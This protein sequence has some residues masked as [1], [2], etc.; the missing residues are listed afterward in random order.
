MSGASIY[1]LSSR[2]IGQK[3]T[4]D[5]VANNVA[6]VNTHG[7]KKQ[8]VDFEEIIGGTVAKPAGHFTIDRGFANDL[9]QGGMEVTHNPLDMALGTDGFFMIEMNGQQHYTRNG[10]FT[11]D[12]DGNLVT[13]RGYP[14]LDANG[15]PIVL[16]VDA[17]QISVGQDGTIATEQGII[18]QVGVVTFDVNTALIRV[19]DN[20]FRNDGG[21][22]GVPANETARVLQ[23]TLETSNV[24]AVL[25]TVQM[26]ETL[27]SYQ[28]TQR[29][30][31]TLEELEQRAIRDLPSRQ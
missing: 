2:G 13:T 21:G 31:Q 8:R 9:A 7:Y 24:N 26:T 16:P 17:R 22:V 15:A 1:I 10:Q 3:K 25:E 20:L 29:M 4:M 28:N 27:R 11:I 12:A 6:N 30:I 14:V 18:A 5:A 23:G 19:G